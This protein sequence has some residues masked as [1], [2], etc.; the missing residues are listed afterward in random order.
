MSVSYNPKTTSDGIIV[1]LDAANPKSFSPNVF[2]YPTDIYSWINSPTGLRCNL[3]RDT[4]SSPVGNTPLRMDITGEDPY[5]NTYGSVPWSIAPAVDGQS[6]TLSIW[7]K[8][9]VDT[10]SAMIIFGAQSTSVWTN[11]GGDIVGPTF[12]VYT[13]WTRVSCSITFANA[14]ITY[15]QVRLD[16]TNAS[17]TGITIWWDGLQLERAGAVTTFNPRPNPNGTQWVDYVT[18]NTNTIYNYPTISPQY[19]TFDGVDDYCQMAST[20]Y[21]TTVDDPFSMELM[22]NIPSSATWAD[23]YIGAIFTRD[24][25]SGMIGIGRTTTNNQIIFYVRGET[26][27]PTTS[28][29]ATISR[30]TWHHVVGVRVNNTCYLYVNGV[31]IS[32]DASATTGTLTTAVWYIGSIQAFAG[33]VGNRFAGSISMARVYSRALSAS[34]VAQNF[35][36]LRRRF[37]I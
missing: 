1:S 8:A 26:L 25:Y 13:Y 14:G 10:T 34:E 12:N 4:I 11:T 17:G 22:L 32:S 24:A 16:G 31:L 3:S 36:A 18:A 5:T 19:I 15:V 29:L 6:W 33:N 21:P 9:S 27:A 20:A 35:N 2:P 23:T 37:G 28:P 7:V 30:D